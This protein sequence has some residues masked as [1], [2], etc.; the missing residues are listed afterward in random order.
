MTLTSYWPRP[1]IDLCGLIHSSG[2][3]W[4]QMSSNSGFLNVPFA[5]F[6]ETQKKNQLKSQSSEIK[7]SFFN[8]ISTENRLNQQFTLKQVIERMQSA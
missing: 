5:I 8:E 7:R 1:S 4:A 2:D 6:M 3:N